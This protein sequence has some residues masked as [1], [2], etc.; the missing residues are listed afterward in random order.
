MAS[1]AD[2]ADLVNLAVAASLPADA[3]VIPYEER[4]N[5][6]RSWALSEGSLFFEGQG[7]V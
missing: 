2:S 3:Q 6:D 1:V 4:L 7:K 5:Q